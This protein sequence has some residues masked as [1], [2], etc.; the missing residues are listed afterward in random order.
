MP[1][2][3]IVHGGLVITDTDQFDADIVIDDGL[4][5]AIISDASSLDA[6]QRIDA[7][8]LLILPGAIDTRVAFGDPGPDPL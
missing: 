5:S 2:R 4:I 8:E 6:D 1:V 3:T 7:H